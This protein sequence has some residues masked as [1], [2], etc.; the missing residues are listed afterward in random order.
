MSTLFGKIQPLCVP[1]EYA[2]TPEPVAL[3]GQDVWNALKALHPLGEDSSL[4][5]LA[6][7]ITSPQ[8]LQNWSEEDSEDLSSSTPHF[9][10]WATAAPE[11]TGFRVPRAWEARYPHIFP[12]P[13]SPNH[14]A[15][16]SFTHLVT[17]V[18]PVALA[19]LVVVALSA[20][21]Y[22]L[23]N[24]DSS[25]IETF[26]CEERDIVRQGSTYAFSVPTA[27][28]GTHEHHEDESTGEPSFTFQYKVIMA[29]PVLQGY[30]KRGY[31]QFFVAKG[32][33]ELPAAPG[34]LEGT[35]NDAVTP[36]YSDDSFEIDEKFLASSVLGD[37]ASG[38]IALTNEWQEGGGS[39]S[40]SPLGGAESADGNS[41]GLSSTTT[42]HAR[43][44]SY[45]EFPYAPL[46]LEQ[47][48]E[49]LIFVR[50][51]D[52][53]KIGIFSGDWAVICSKSGTYSRL[54]RVF[55]NDG[56]ARSQF[57]AAASPT[58]FYNAGVTS[59]FGTDT[60]PFTIRAT[61]FG[62]RSPP[63]PT[64]RAV[65][66]ARVASP[67]AN[68]RTFQPLFL[69]GLK[70]YFEGKI[71]LLKKGD[72]VAVGIDEDSVHLVGEVP[73][74]SGE[75]DAPKDSLLD[76]EFPLA[77]YRPTNVVFFKITNLEYDVV[78]TT[79]SH[80]P[81]DVYVAA[82]MGELGC[83]IDP[84]VTKMVQAGV[85]HSRIPDVAAYM[86]LNNG[87]PALPLGSSYTLTSVGTP[88]AKLFDVVAAS[89]LPSAASYDLQLSVILKGARGIG[90]R[91]IVR[92]VA[93]KLGIHVLEINCF[94]V[95]G[96]SDTKT[97]GT[98]RARFEKAASCSPCILLLRHI[99]ALATTSQT[100]E[101]GREPA[102]TTV[103]P[104]CI[105]DLR[106]T[107]SLTGYPA[108]AIGTTSD[109]E[110]V[111]VSVLSAFKH[112]ISFEVP[113][114]LERLDILKGLVSHYPLSPDVSLKSIATQT[115][116][117]VPND[118][119]DL[120]SRARV[121]SMERAMKESSISGATE[122]DL[123]HAGVPLTGADFTL[124]LSK[125]RES[126]SESIGA[127][128][129]PNV[130]WDDVGG[131]AKVKTDILD[132]IQ[133]PLEHPELFADG[134]KQRSGILLYG[135]P[136]T[137]KTLLAKAVATSCSLNF[138]SIK[139]PELLNMYIGESEANVR[140]VFQKA[141]DAK[142]CVIFFDELDSIAPKRGNH[143]DS[144]GVMDR[145]V[146]QLLAELDGMSDG[147]GGADVFVIGATNRPDLLDPALL[148]PGRFDRM[149]Y[150]GVSDTHEAQLKIL[151]A[152]TRKFRLDP[153]L[154][155]KHVADQ[156]PFNYTGADFYALCSD[157][158]LKA[159]SRKAQEIDAKIVELNKLPP[160]Y[161]HPHPMTPQYYLAEIATSSETD[162]LV[163]L[164]DFQQALQEL[165]PSVS[166]SEMEHYAA[167]QKRFA[168]DTINSKDKGK[169]K[170]KDMEQTPTS[171]AGTNA[172]HDFTAFG[173]EVTVAPL[174]PSANKGKG[175][176][177]DRYMPE[178]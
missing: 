81:P 53:G 155:L 74:A 5:R 35:S 82:T 163:S 164:Q 61:P 111:P 105:A 167:V 133:L 2:D 16:P 92:W 77:S 57:S 101:T 148:R 154:D 175:K 126:Y 60:S 102:M 171:L 58:F 6:I 145:I 134:L 71:R 143:G 79:D 37:L 153:G 1:V 169:G 99:D 109:A 115:A 23:S 11:S 138:F 106:Q 137:G 59:H 173:D 34:A 130:S 48:T 75:K 151:E 119:A 7:S 131:L 116:A 83:W 88:F 50:N 52:L 124:A 156:C 54:A 158:M 76:H 12:A 178:D 113:G 47:D 177:V 10:L 96:E 27:T 80:A 90:K 33:W 24:S 9:M 128:N 19:E 26:F 107:W 43:S 22:E 122:L 67:L 172:N 55:A 15:T 65:T 29:Q 36:D 30:V 31:T 62:F 44:L 118:L 41:R 110:H 78:D 93:Q 56:L 51:G 86:G 149:L 63:V 132:T 176:A 85:E 17:P 146:S 72:L 97:E 95:V 174:V 32:D 40:P 144:G 161:A 166:Q 89:L 84:K 64:A 91:T 38:S 46:A 170:G 98:L 152:L 142:P 129:I 4:D 150:L 168:N 87:C 18:R 42:F 157:A 14:S 120:V 121:A 108:I 114:E 127:P 70:R 104:E 160:P 94:D 136:G 68:D 66:V 147:K 49:P 123:A 125:A 135:P 117:L 100:L 139:G 103:L 140:R 25:Q 165:V 159:M 141:R 13:E 3:L 39:L 20:S 21:A 69:R 162:V 45:S 28:N 112:E 8:S 73:D